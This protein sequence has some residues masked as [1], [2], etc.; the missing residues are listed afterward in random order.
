MRYNVAHNPLGAVPNAPLA[1][2]PGKELRPPILNMLEIH[3]GQ[4]NREREII[5]MVHWKLS[6]RNNHGTVGIYDNT[7]QI[8]SARHYRILK[9]K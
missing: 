2:A 1:S 6:P 5:R 8:N 9:L 3:G 4:V 7:P